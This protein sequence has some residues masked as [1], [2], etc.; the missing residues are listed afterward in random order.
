M[1]S[2]PRAGVGEPSGRRVGFPR[3]LQGAADGGLAFPT[4]L[5]CQICIFQAKLSGDQYFLN[6]MW[7]SAKA[8]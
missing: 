5:K 4:L 3:E 6:I 7:K 8:V 2:R 1:I